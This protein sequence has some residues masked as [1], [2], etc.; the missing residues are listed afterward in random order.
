MIVGVDFGKHIGLA[1]AVGSMAVP[2]CTVNCIKEAASKIIEKKA[3]F[4]IIGWP[5]LLNGK[6]GEQC[7]LTKQMLDELLKFCN[8]PYK[9]QDERFSSR[10]V[11][12]NHVNKDEHAHSAAWILQTYLNVGK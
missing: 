4:L 12:K 1:Y 5:L 6:E 3:T 8:L 9:L 11:G 2:Y 10:F 7:L